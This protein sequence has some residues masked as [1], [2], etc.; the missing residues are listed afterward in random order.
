MYGRNRRGGVSEAIH[1]VSEGFK[2]RI[3]ADELDA[4]NAAVALWVCGR[5]PDV[6]TGVE[7]AKELLLGGAVHGVSYGQYAL[8]IWKANATPGA[9]AAGIHG[10][11]RSVSALTLLPELQPLPGRPPA[12]GRRRRLARRS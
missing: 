9:E 11:Q 8:D 10:G 3:G 12:S 4:L 2:A 6:R 5:T 7:R 1:P